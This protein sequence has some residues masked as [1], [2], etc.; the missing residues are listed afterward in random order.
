MALATPQAQD[1]KSEGRPAE[2]TLP[3]PEY[4]RPQFMRNDWI[5]L[6]GHWSFAFDFGRSGYQRNFHKSTGFNNQILVPF[7]P[8]SRMS[9]VAYDDFIETVWYHRKLEIPEKWAGQRMLLHFGAVDYESEIFIDGQSV[10]VHWGGSSSFSIDLTRFVKPGGTHDLIVYVRDEVR[11]GVQTG[12]KQSINFKSEGCFYTR[13]AGIWQTVWMEAIPH[14]AVRTCH[15]IPD[16]DHSQFMVIPD[17]WAQEQGMKLKIS[18]YDEGKEVQQVEAL[19]LTGVPVVAE[20]SNPKVWA[21]GSP[22]LYDLKFELT[23]RDGKV[24]D[25]ITSYAGLRKTH[26][27]GDKVYLNNEPLYLRLVLDQ[28]FYEDGIWTAPTD[29]DFIKDIKLSMDAGFNGARLHQKVFEERFHYWA[30]KMGYLTWAESPSWALDVKSEIAAR[31]FLTEWREVVLRDRN[32][33]SIIA[34]TPLNETWDTGN[35]RQSRRLH[36]EAYELTRALDPTRPVND[37]S[38][39]CHFQTDLYT[40]HIYEQDP[41]KLREKLMMKEDGEVFRTLGDKEVPYEGQPYIVDE[42]GG[43]KWIPQGR[44]PF[45]DNSW[46]YGDSPH[47]LDEFYS[48]LEGQVDALLSL[49]HICGYCYTQLTDVEQEENGLYNY[50]RSDKF[51]VEKLRKVFQ[52]KPNGYI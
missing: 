38:G 40:V 19:A 24:V 46:G 7:C 11:S 3:R 23:G 47:T 20:L 2:A 49:P 33:P 10:G 26:I 8:E 41:E 35:M 15:I 29:E 48:R 14:N 42:F 30:D 31:N 32:H 36:V 44:Q 28:G 5:N 17:F 9:G 18:V 13:T 51:D 45:A 27:S 16:L 12:G 43:I 1:P 50:D 25:T 39:G 6:N 4:P 21:P 52:K 22:H 37:A 34:W